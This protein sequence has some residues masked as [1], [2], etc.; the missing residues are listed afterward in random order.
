MV[1]I[2]SEIALKF[3]KLIC[4]LH[5]IESLQGLL[6]DLHRLLYSSVDMREQDIWFDS[7]MLSGIT[8]SDRVQVAT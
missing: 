2:P 8:E 6:N 3:V 7:H 1:C 5:S 4:A